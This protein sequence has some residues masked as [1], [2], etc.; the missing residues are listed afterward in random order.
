MSTKWK[1]N[2]NIT[3]ITTKHKASVKTICAT[4]G[5]E[6][7]GRVIICFRKLCDNIAVPTSI[8]ADLFCGQY[9][10]WISSEVHQV[11]LCFLKQDHIRSRGCG[12]GGEY[13][14]ELT[15]IDVPSRERNGR[16]VDL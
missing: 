5:C 14:Y 9:R 3:N 16:S 11:Y 12:S 10:A 6:L 8:V 4:P 1:R 2:I 15:V 7:I 13:T